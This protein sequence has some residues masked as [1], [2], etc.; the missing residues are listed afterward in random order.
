MRNPVNFKSQ[1]NSDREFNKKIVYYGLQANVLE[2]ESAS[3]LL[4]DATYRCCGH[5]TV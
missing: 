2:V 5:V 3:G 4:P 1:N